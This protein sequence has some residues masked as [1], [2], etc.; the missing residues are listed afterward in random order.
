MVTLE[1]LAQAALARDH[2]RL[3]SLTHDLLRQHEK[4][5]EL[6]SPATASAQ[7][8]SVAAGLVELLALRRQE[9]APEWVEAVGPLKEPF[10]LLEA[11]RHFKHLR[12]LCETES[13]EPLRR[14]NLLA[15]PDFLTFA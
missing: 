6:T 8:L 3:R 12:R 2:L 11:A 5:A 15:P 9:P 10:Y 4:L 14:R 7:V 13:P 1:E